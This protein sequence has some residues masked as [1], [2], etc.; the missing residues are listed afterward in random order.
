MSSKQAAKSGN[1]T[2][3][4]NGKNPKKREISTITD[5]NG[6]NESA[7]SSSSSILDESNATKRSKQSDSSYDKL[8]AMLDGIN[9]KLD[10][11]NKKTDKI[12]DIDKA[13][14]EFKEG[15]TK[16]NSNV[17][18]LQQD[19]DDISEGLENVQKEVTTIK[20]DR[21]AIETEV[22]KINLI[23]SGIGDEDNEPES[24]LR[25]KVQNEINSIVTT[26]NVKIDTVSRLGRY[27]KDKTRLIKVR[28]ATMRERDLVWKNHTKT[29]PPV[30]INLDLPKNTL[31]VHAELRK[32]Q[33]ELKAAKFLTKI[34]YNRLAVLT[35][36]KTYKLNPDSTFDEIDEKNEIA[37]PIFL[38]R[39]PQ[40]TQGTN[41][42]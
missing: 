31:K 15:L 9:I 30:F 20:T 8:T 11:L 42:N 2:T 4:S 10:N 39:K 16:T 29:Q 6:H 17:L 26:E 5:T 24:L 3:G 40:S 37:P 27:S 28:F 7:S 1:K 14:K 34:N 41:Q 36:S 25:S 19:V 23:M 32:K 18:K 35:P 12:D 22:K 38:V 13:I 33:R 21:D